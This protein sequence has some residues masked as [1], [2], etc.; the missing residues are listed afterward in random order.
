MSAEVALTMFNGRLIF[1]YTSRVES[2]NRKQASTPDTNH[3]ELSGSQ[4]INTPPLSGG[5]G[6]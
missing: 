3:N 1:S 4:S 2:A 5:S 6:I